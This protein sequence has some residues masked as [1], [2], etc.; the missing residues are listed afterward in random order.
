MSVAEPS[1]DMW[2]GIC[3]RNSSFFKWFIWFFL[4]NID[5]NIDRIG[6]EGLPI[7]L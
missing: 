7:L 3:K 4:V 6:S 2:N 1:L 5:V